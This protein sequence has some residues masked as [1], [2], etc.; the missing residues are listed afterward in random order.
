MKFLVFF[1]LSFLS[2]ELHAQIVERVQ[3]Q[4]SEE[5]ISLID[6]KNFQRQLR[7]GL[8]PPSLLLKQLYKKPELLTDKNKLLDF[9][10][11]RNLLSQMAKKEKLPEIDKKDLEKSLQ[12][13]KGSL[14]K[15]LFARKLKKAGL[16]LEDLKQQ[17]IMDLKNDRLLSQ[18]VI[19]KITLSEQDL[20]S[21]HFN[22]YNTALFTNFEYE[23]ISVSFPENK[24][25]K[26]L[27]HLRR[28][29]SGSLENLARSLNLEFKTLKLK[30][31][32]IHK[33]FKKE[34]DKLSVSQVSPLLLLG[35]SYYALQLK[36][37]QPQISPKKQKRKEQIEQ[38]LY[39]KKLRKE[40]Q[41]WIER[42][43]ASSSLTY[44]SL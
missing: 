25:K 39:K 42:K 10:I 1:F 2:L 11:N 40:L 5:M 32:E 19:S 36:W 43:K 33:L 22:R 16:E 34:L 44:Y 41:K 7:L 17:I 12:G 35:N 21:F 6:L 24:K 8:V 31:K 4:I 20:E 15:K 23:F 13:L 38:I 18:F 37:K 30:D 3:A 14:S 29:A 28:K 9:M 27:K 26:F